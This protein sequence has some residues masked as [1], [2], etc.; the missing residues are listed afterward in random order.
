MISGQIFQNLLQFASPWKSWESYSEQFEY[1]LMGFFTGNGLEKITYCYFPPTIL[2]LWS[3]FSLH[4]PISIMGKYNLLYNNTC[5]HVSFLEL[6]K[7]I[8]KWLIA[9]IIFLIY[10]NI[11][12][13]VSSKLVP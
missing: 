8:I 6:G 3:N 1:K 7:I 5:I 11:L 2:F 13:S 4:L 10:M 9:K 12:N